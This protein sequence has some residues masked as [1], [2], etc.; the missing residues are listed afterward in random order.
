MSKC[1]DYPINNIDAE[2]VPV[3]G[4][5][6]LPDEGYL[7]MAAKLV[8][9]QCG[10]ALPFLYH[11]PINM[12]T[13]GGTFQTNTYSA[14]GNGF[15]SEWAANQVRAGYTYNNTPNDIRFADIVEKLAQYLI[16]KKD[17]GISGNYIIQGNGFYTFTGGHEYIPGYAYYLGDNGQPTTETAYV[18]GRRQ[19][20]FEV[21]DKS[22]ILINIYIEN[23]PEA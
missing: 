11:L 5:N 22:T 12:V 6:V 15:T 17:D 8:D 1:N 2:D 16:L 14:N 10:R 13:P 23:D 20:L 7:L 3:W 21:I 18:N 9:Q 4:K 19:H